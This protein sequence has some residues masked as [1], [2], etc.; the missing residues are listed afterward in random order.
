MK[1]TAIFLQN[2]ELLFNG[3]KLK[4]TKQEINVLGNSI[5]EIISIVNK[6]KIKNFYLS[7]IKPAE[8]EKI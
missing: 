4:V 1:Y 7:G 8:Y 3:N 2:E 5:E 6:L